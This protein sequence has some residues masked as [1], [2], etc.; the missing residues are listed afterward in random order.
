M[1]EE[2]A[3]GA[4]DRTRRRLSVV[5]QPAEGTRIVLDLRPG[6]LQGPGS[7]DL[8]CGLCDEPLARGLPDARFDKLRAAV[9]SMALRRGGARVSGEREPLILRCPVCR[10]YNELP[11]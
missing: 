8:V 9:I 2:G 7:V 4:N 6:G 10:A 3:Q 11:A 1:S 5:P